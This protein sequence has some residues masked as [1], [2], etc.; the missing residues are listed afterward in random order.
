MAFNIKKTFLAKRVKRT[1]RLKQWIAFVVIIFCV[2]NLLIQWADFSF[3]INNIP[4]LETMA[5]SSSQQAAFTNY[6][7]VNS[8]KLDNFEATLSGN[9]GK[10]DFYPIE[11][12]EYLPVYFASNY[13][14]GKSGII[15]GSLTDLTDDQR[16][17]IKDELVAQGADPS[18]VDGFLQYKIL[19]ANPEPSFDIVYTICLAVIL[20]Y[21]LYIFFINRHYK[22]KLQAHKVFKAFVR[23]GGEVENFHQFNDEW[24]KGNALKFKHVIL[25][26]H[27]V[28]YNGM[29][30]LKLRNVEDIVCCFK[31]K[32]LDNSFLTRWATKKQDVVIGFIDKSQMALRFK[33]NYNRMDEFKNTLK[34]RLPNIVCD[35]DDAEIAKKWFNTPSDVVDEYAQNVYHAENQKEIAKRKAAIS[36]DENN[37]KEKQ[38]AREH[39][40]VS[41]KDAEIIEKTIGEYTPEPEATPTW[42][43]R[44][45]KD[46]KKE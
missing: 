43:R 36:E 32:S 13:S 1:S 20:I 14:I 9:T 23:A 16:A 26:D 11:S 22:R 5:Q 28:F 44:E 27:W 24:E 7:A 17:E 30:R 39:N 35:N 37:N 10:I 2:I 21:A 29:F 45:R 6:W 4:I 18:D 40:V 25:T 38:A 31:T 3:N 12:G 19:V 8:Q 42:R 15:F 46:D 41:K 33:K 34:N